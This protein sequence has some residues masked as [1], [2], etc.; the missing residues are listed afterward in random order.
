MITKIKTFFH[1]RKV[2]AMKKVHDYDLVQLKNLRVE[3]QRL[4]KEMREMKYLL[5]KFQKLLSVEAVY[6]RQSVVRLL[7]QSLCVDAVLNPLY[8]K[9]MLVQAHKLIHKTYFTE[10]EFPSFVWRGTVAKFKENDFVFYSEQLDII[11]WKDYPL[12]AHLLIEWISHHQRII[13]GEVHLQPYS[14]ELN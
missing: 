13:D 4:G 2:K 7:E 8:D 14:V 5:L 6:K 11:E 9:P 1:N 3:N 10:G 12:D